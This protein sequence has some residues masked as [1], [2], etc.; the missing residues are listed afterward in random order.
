MIEAA[1]VRIKLKFFAVRMI[2]KPKSGRL[3]MANNK[4]GLP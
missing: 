4:S 2:E 1:A 3:A